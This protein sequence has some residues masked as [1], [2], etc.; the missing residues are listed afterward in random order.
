MGDIDDL[1]RLAE[2]VNVDQVILAL[3]LSERERIKAAIDKLK[4]LPGEVLISVAPIGE[5]LA[6]RGLCYIGGLPMLEIVGRPIKRWAAII[7]SIEDK[8]LALL[9]LLISAPLMIIIAL[10]IKW[11][12]CGPVLFVQERLGFNNKV[13]NILNFRTMYVDCADRT[14]ERRT[15]R[16]DPRVTRVGRVLRATSLDEVPQLINVLKGDMSLVGPR[17]HATAMKVG[18]HFY[19]DAIDEYAQRHRV[20]P[21]IT[22]WAQINGFRGEVNSLEKGR[23][24]VV[25]DL[26]YIER[27]SIWF[28][29]K[30]LLLTLPAVW[31]RQNA[32]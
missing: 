16:K 17:P 14:G 21:G 2:R 12:S 1:L 15:V 5:A 26:H 27:W 8:T 30:I 7:K 25:Y 31:S 29:L 4:R 22:G 19:C 20:K 18:E 9:G 3:P 23:A 24:R 32:Y 11:D 13:I 28:D 6:V 10:L